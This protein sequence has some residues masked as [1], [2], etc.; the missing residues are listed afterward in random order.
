[1]SRKRKG[2]GRRRSF[3]KIVL[4]W[5]GR[6][7]LGRVQKRSLRSITERPKSRRFRIPGALRRSGTTGAPVSAGVRARR[8]LQRR[9]PEVVEPANTPASSRRGAA[10]NRRRAGRGLALAVLTTAAVAAVKF[11]AERVIESEREQHVVTPDFDVFADDD[12]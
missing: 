3:A 6:R 12:E 11:G 2:K 1:M 5:L 8:W 10:L 9:R 4:L 7:L